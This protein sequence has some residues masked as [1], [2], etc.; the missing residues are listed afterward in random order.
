VL[1]NANKATNGR[2]VEGVDGS[3]VKA[4]N[5]NN[6]PKTEVRDG[7]IIF[8]ILDGV[9]M[10]SASRIRSIRRIG[11]TAVFVALVVQ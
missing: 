2:N 3:E 7:T 1:F 5:R 6:E 4:M 8:C 9:P 10:H 11:T